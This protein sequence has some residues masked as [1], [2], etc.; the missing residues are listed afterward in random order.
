MIHSSLFCSCCASLTSEI[1]L[2]LWHD[3]FLPTQ[4]KHTPSFIRHSQMNEMVREMGQVFMTMT[5]LLLI[6]T[7]VMIN[8]IFVLT[9]LC[10]VISKA[11]FLCCRTFHKL[12]IGFSSSVSAHTSFI[13]EWLLPYFAQFWHLS[14]AFSLTFQH[15]EVSFHLLLHSALEF[16]VSMIHACIS[17]CIL[18]CVLEGDHHRQ[19]SLQERIRHLPYQNPLHFNLIWPCIQ[20]LFDVRVLSSF[21]KKTFGTKLPDNM[22]LTI[23][24]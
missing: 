10:L 4:T 1:K 17:C 14:W 15:I 23:V 9:F 16:L 21:A 8:D 22:S 19:F 18:Q 7:R 11:T 6:S 5:S 2:F 13:F 24:Q 12:H 20:R 3:D